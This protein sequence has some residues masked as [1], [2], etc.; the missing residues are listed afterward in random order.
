M[1]TQP[2]RSRR[3]LIYCVM[4]LITMCAVGVTATR[5]QR[6]VRLPKIISKVKSL[7][8]ISATLERQDE[9][10]P[11]VS[12]E[13]RNN[14]E[15]PIIAVALEQGDD[16]DAYGINRN[17]YRGDEPPVVVIEPHET[18][19]LEI[20]LSNLKENVPIRVAGVIYADDTEAGEKAAL[21]TMRR[22]QAHEKAKRNAKKGALPQ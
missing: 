8:V 10:L 18:I 6:E 16:R 21:G 3:I 9:S 13:I 15:K 20:P 19:T 22:Q 7:E 11:V 2:T 1:R 17:G 12:V 5:Q 14:S 4:G